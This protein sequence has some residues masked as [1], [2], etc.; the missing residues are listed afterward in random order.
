[1]AV[2]KNLPVD[3]LVVEP[4]AID[5]EHISVGTRINKMEPDL[6]MDLA[7]SGKVR[8]YSKELEKD[9]D[10]RVKAEEAAAKKRAEQGNATATLVANTAPSVSGEELAA[11]VQAGIAQGIEAGLKLLAEAP[12]PIES[13]PA[14][15]GGP[16]ENKA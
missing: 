10:A 16:E 2:N 7:G 13:A 12:A 5:G 4:T 14:A 6:A 15:S 11:A 9:L 8:L 3:V 1:M